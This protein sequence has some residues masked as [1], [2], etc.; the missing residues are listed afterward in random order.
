MPT[1]AQI[2]Q[3]APAAAAALSKSITHKSAK[4]ASRRI[5]LAR[6][7]VRN[8]KRVLIVRVMSTHRTERIKIRVGKHTYRRT[9]ATNHRVKVTNVTLPAKAKVSVTLG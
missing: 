9:V 8:G 7:A 5:S 3:T 6:V 2:Q 1:L 4:K